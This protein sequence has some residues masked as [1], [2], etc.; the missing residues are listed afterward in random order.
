TD[1]LVE[2]QRGV[3]PTETLI[4]ISALRELKY[5][6]DDGDHIALGALTTHNDVV[7]SPLVV[8][9]ALPLAQAS[10]EVGAPQIRA[11]AT[12]AGNV[13]TASPANDTIPPLVALGAEMVLTSQAG[14]RVVPIAEFYPGFRRT[15]IGAD[16]MLREIRVPKLAANQRGVFRKL[17]LRQAQAISV[18]DF[19]LVLSFDGDVVVEARI[20]LG[21]VAP[22]IVRSPTAERYLVGKRLSREVCAE[23]G[24]LVCQD[25]API[26]DLRGSADYR[27]AT[28]ESLVADV[29]ER[30]AS[31]DAEARERKWTARRVLLETPVSQVEG[32][33][34]FGGVIHTTINGQQRALGG[35]ALRKTLLDALREEAG[36]TGTKE[37]CAEGEC[38]ACTVWLNGQAVMSCL[39]P[40]AQAHNG[41][42]TTIEGLAQVG[43]S[44]EEG[45]HPL[46]QAF[47]ESGAVQCGFCI[48]GMLMAGAKLLQENPKPDADAARVALSGNICR[49]TGY[50]KI[51]DAVVS[52]GEG[53]V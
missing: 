14:E 34:P 18:I 50:R 6:R 35:E 11:R 38:G 24:R 41:A 40:A 15:V 7:A 23:A 19:A 47:I 17:G 30:L 36:L 4:D 25:V 43:P 13:I 22:T 12:I 3:K 26:D 27:R 48:P 51:V 46:Q 2:L 29:L 16:E 37:G 42:V 1:V 32:G 33:E 8:G 39:V 28:V 52:A 5:I 49:C 21:C 45:L 20:A 53:R 9:P 31:E 10:W 44:T